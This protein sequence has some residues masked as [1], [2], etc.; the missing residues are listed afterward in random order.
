MFIHESGPLG[1][2]TIVFLHGNGANGGMWKSHMQVLSD[3]HCLA[4]DF[5]GFGHSGSQEWVSLQATT[6]EVL[7]LVHEH[8]PQS[9]VHIVGLS[10]GGS[11]AMTWLSTAPHLVD[12]AI[13]DG[14]GVQPLPGLAFMKV[15]FRLMQPFMHTD[16]VI[17]TIASMTKIPAEDYADFKQ[18]MLSM[19]PSSFTRSF[20]QASSMSLPPGL[21]NVMCRVLL[22]AGER[23][24]QVVK[25]SQASLA[26]LLPNAENYLALGLGHGWL[27]EAPDLHCSMVRAWIQD[28]AMPERLVGG[29]ET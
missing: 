21:E 9:K 5:P 8:T 11:V 7:K 22:V 29:V 6:E 16:F 2:P 20:L 15:G 10:L 26:G 12:H 1:R 24:P 4:P 14:A 27:A 3:Y 18:G 28:E 25:E 23:E 17:R 13:V 19:S